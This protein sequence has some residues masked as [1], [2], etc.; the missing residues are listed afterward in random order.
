MSISRCI[1]FFLIV[2]L[3]ENEIHLHVAIQN[4]LSVILLSEKS[5]ELM[6]ICGCMQLPSLLS[7][8]HKYGFTHLEIMGGKTQKK[9]SV[10]FIIS[11]VN[12]TRHLGR[13]AGFFVFFFN[14]GSGKYFLCCLKCFNMCILF[15]IIKKI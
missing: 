13:K 7:P 11:L 3:K 9:L 5:R 10:V 6:S 14:G 1:S 15:F 2:A 12:G 4:I 8:S